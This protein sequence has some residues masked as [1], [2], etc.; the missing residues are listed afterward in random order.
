LVCL[1]N[2]RDSDIEVMV[3]QEESQ[4][5]NLTKNHSEGVISTNGQL[6]AQLSQ[7]E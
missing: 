3:H 2:I 6:G 4:S 7:E 5:F 1:Q